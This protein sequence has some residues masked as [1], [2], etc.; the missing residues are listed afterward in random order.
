MSNIIG[1]I[2]L[3]GGAT[4]EDTVIS[5]I[6]NVGS[7]KKRVIAEGTLQDMDVENRNHRIYARAD[8]SPEINGP[9]MTELIKAKEMKGELGHPLSDDLV[10]QQTIDPKLVCVLFTKIWIE[11]NKVKGQFKGTNNAYG[12]EFDCDLRDG[13]KP[14]FSLRAL[15]S[16]EN[17]NGKAYVKNI[18]II[19]YDRVIFPSHRAAYTEKIV[20][21][22]AIDGTPVYENGIYVTKDDPGRIINLKGTD[23]KTVISR[24]QRESANLD[25]IVNTFDG[26]MDKISLVN[27][28][29]VMMTNRFGDKFYVNLENHIENLINEFCIKN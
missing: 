10:R 28:S 7:G 21:E 26:I 9:R 29:T 18:K 27:E 17:I 6:K 1:S 19:T 20:S 11:G 8:L 14:A 4:V 13:C 22:S 16:V 12:D 23:A 3:E 24:L 15:G 2:I 25:R 5:D